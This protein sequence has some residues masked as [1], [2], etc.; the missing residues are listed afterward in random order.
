MGRSMGTSHDLTEP[1]VRGCATRNLTRSVKLRVV[2]FR[3]CIY[4]VPRDGQRP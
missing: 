4:E 1:F 3:L 2:C